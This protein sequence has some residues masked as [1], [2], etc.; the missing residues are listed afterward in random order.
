MKKDIICYGQVNQGKW[1]QETYETAS[2]DARQRANELRKLG[3]KV[4]TGPMGS[5][6]TSVGVVKLTMVDIL[7]GIHKDTFKIP[8]VKIVKI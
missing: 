1:C 8:N 4:S 5:Q 6:V 7:P 3:Y 2:K